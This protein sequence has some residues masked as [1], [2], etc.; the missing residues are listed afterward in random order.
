[1]ILKA[2][3]LQRNDIPPAS[4]KCYSIPK[5]RS[6]SKT[7]PQILCVCVLRYV[8]KSHANRL[9]GERRMDLIARTCVEELYK[10]LNLVFT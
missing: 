3:V 8:K 7:F 5:N 9:A 1:M 10:T 6:P 4:S 2:I